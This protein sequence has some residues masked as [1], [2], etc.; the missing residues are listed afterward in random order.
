MS[1]SE[2]SQER[3]RIEHIEDPPFMRSLFSAVKWSWLWLL[4]RVYIGFTWLRAGWGK[5]HNPSWVGPTSGE[6]LSGFVQ[7]AL[8]KMSGE[9]P[10]VQSWY[11]S[12][13]QHEV[14]PH[15]AFW[16]HLV[17]YGELLVGAAL[18][19]GLFTGIAAFWGLFMNMNYLLAGSV[20]VNPIL[21]VIAILLVLAWK[22]AGWW[23]L[24]RWLLPALGTPW[25]PGYLFHEQDMQ[26][27]AQ[28]S[29]RPA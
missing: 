26:R 15:S 18:I 8:A 27:S 9:H 11:G 16:S 22:T 13:L 6:A 29:G 14:L 10:D 3:S 17:A 1:Q 21:L 12:F 7:G 19:L 25:S 2:L 5:V 23:G 20:S 24:D 28:R 4:A